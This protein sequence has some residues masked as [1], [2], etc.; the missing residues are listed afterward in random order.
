M[1]IARRFPGIVV[2]ALFLLT[3]VSTATAKYSGGTGEPNDPYQIATAAD[4]IA[5]GDEPNDYDKHFILTADIDLDPNLPGRKVFDKAV[6]APG[7][8]IYD[9]YDGYYFEGVPFS[10]DFD[11]NGHTISHLTIMGKDYV[12]LI[13]LLGGVDDNDHG[14]V[15]SLGVVDVS[16]RGS[17]SCVGGLVGESHGKV[18][19]CY[20]S[21]LIVAAEYLGGLVGANFRDISECYSSAAVRGDDCVGGL[22][23]VNAGEIAR[24]YSSGPVTGNRTVGGFVGSHVWVEDL[25]DGMRAF[26]FGRVID[27]FWDTE[28]SGQTASD[29]GAGRSTAEMCA[30]ATFLAWGICGHEGV[31]T[32][33]EEKDYPRLWWEN[34]QGEPIQSPQ[35][36]DLLMGNGTEDDPFLIYTPGELNMVGLYPCESDKHFKLMA[37]L[38]LSGTKYSEA[39]IPVLKGSF[40]GNGHIVSHLT[41]TGG[42]YLGLFGQLESEAEVRHLGAVDVNISGSGSYVGALAGENYGQVTHSYSTGTVKGRHSVGGLVGLNGGATIHCHSTAEVAG[43]W[44]WLGGLVGLNV[45][46]I[47][48]SYCSGSVTGIDDVGGLVG[49]NGGSITASY[50][51]G[52]VSGSGK[53]IGGLVGYN[54]VGSVTD[55]YST[56]AVNGTGERIGGLVGFNQKGPVADCYSTGRVKGG[57][58]VG[59]LVGATE[60]W[61]VVTNCFWDT[62]TSGQATSA[63]GSGYATAAMQDIGSFLR[64]GWDFGDEVSN[65]TCD[66]WQVSPGGYPQLCYQTGS[67]P[68]MPEGLGTPEQPY[69]IRDARDLGTVWFEPLAH[70]RLVQSVDL[71]G[72]TWSASVIPSFGG[73]LDG[74]GHVISNL[75]IRGGSYLG[76][77]GELRPAGSVFNLGLEAVEVS[78]SSDYV[79]SLVGDNS[80]GAVACCYSTGSVRGDSAVGGLVGQNRGRVAASYS[81]SSVTG[82]DDVGGLVGFNWGGEVT[83]C[84]S[85]GAVSGTYGVGGLSGFGKAV[86]TNCFWD[87]QTSGQATSDGGTGKT[88]AEMQ[89]ASTFL[90]A[91]WDFVGE[92]ANGT[93]DLWWIDEGQD[94]P[95]LWW[96]PRN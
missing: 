37:D 78:G 40:D 34:R 52:E 29:G 63:G 54:L 86:S 25:G 77:F 18:E 39:V 96:E 11:G 64:A 49:D 3:A 17:G 9:L 13:G 88:T 48:A 83:Q 44:E 74:H 41:I 16:I 95:R 60:Q 43:T 87:I 61:A 19:Y 6:I 90:D 47:T 36:T 12:G 38:D 26:G 72:M 33:D 57:S 94:Y 91:G 22:V 28:T 92:T 50:S 5:L 82:I 55:C 10:G 35:L 80:D 75:Y 46:S 58:Y 32:I 45:G 65:G 81:S 31:W 68:S 89:T 1:S 51:T 24:S 69:L 73:T 7:E 2:V 84:Y 59:G 85:T 79:G 8:R 20:S 27:C 56:G 15:R 76:L 71:S 66:Y 67:R 23:G 70:Y 62:Q 4:L 53:D 30:A 14:E 42:T 21:G 93:D